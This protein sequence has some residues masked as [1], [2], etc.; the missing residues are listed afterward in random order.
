MIGHHGSGERPLQG[1]QGLV[2]GNDQFDPVADLGTKQGEI[3]MLAAGIDDEAESAVIS[4]IGRARDHEIVERAALVV[5]QLGIALT[6]AAEIDDVGGQQRFQRRGHRLV[7]VADQEGLAHMGDVEQ[8]G[9]V[10]GVIVLGDDAGRVLHRHVVPGK[11]HH[12]RTECHMFG[13]KRG[14]QKRQFGCRF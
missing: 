8:A 2:I 14:L 7:A 11:R 9:G 10:A 12:A 13:M 1:E 5:K 4:R 3:G 6:A